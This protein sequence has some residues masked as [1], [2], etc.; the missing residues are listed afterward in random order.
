MNLK[1]FTYPWAV[2]ATLLVAGCGGDGGIGGTGASTGTLRVGITDAPACGYDEVNV[3]IRKLRVHQVADAADTA[4][5]WAEI[6]LSPGKRIDLLSLANGLVENLGQTTL[7]AGKYTQL[8]LVLAPN[9]GSTPFANSVIPTGLAET[10][11]TTPSAQTS[12]LKV[13]A[14]IDVPA[15]KVADFVLDFDACASVVRSGNSG[16]YILKPVIRVIPLLSDAGLRVKGYVDPSIAATANVSLQTGGLPVKATVPDALTGAFLLYPVPAGSYTLVVT[17][18]GRVTSVMTGVPV[19]ASAP[20]AVNSAGMPIAPALAASAPRAVAGT[21]TPA[22]ATVR[23][24]QSL[25][26]GPLVEV[27]WGPV[28]AGSGAFQFALTPDAPTKIAYVPNPVTLIF[29]A[30]T[31]AAGKYSISATAGAATQLQAIDVTNPVPPL[32][33]TFPP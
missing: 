27:A 18:A 6:D 25:T 28:D 21:V 11:L 4:A 30:D 7:P 3:T 32:T 29:V 17:A 26:A 33:F 24:L 16:T 5:G 15:G 20:T 2:A 9:G 10:A 19:I 31:G 22:T 13:N 12:G 1:R 23:A 14:D 8:R